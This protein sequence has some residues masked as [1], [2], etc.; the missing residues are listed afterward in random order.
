MNA[1]ILPFRRPTLAEPLPKRAYTLHPLRWT[2]ARQRYLTL[3]GWGKA[4]CYPCRVYEGGPKRGRT[5]WYPYQVPESRASSWLSHEDVRLLW[6]PVGVDYEVGPTDPR[7]M[8]L[9]QKG[10]ELLIEWER[11]HGRAKSGADTSRATF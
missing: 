9:T 1:V 11:D 2:E 6:Y 3:V 7:A 8:G 10:R 4:Q 5:V